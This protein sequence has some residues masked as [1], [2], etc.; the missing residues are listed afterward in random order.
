MKKS[1]YGP[2]YR[3]ATRYIHSFKIVGKASKDELEMIY[4]KVAKQISTVDRIHT[5][6][7]IFNALNTGK[8]VYTEILPSFSGTRAAYDGLNNI[9][10][11][12]EDADL[13]LSKT[14]EQLFDTG[15]F[16]TFVHEAIHKLQNTKLIYK[17]YP[18]RGMVEGATELMALRANYKNRSF[19]FN[20][21]SYNFNQSPYYH[22]VS[23]MAQLEVIFG[24]D[25]MQRFAFNGDPELMNQFKNMIG[26]DYFGFICQ[27]TYLES[28]GKE[29][30]FN[31]QYLQDFI[32]DTCFDKLFNQVNNLQDAEQ[33]LDKLKKMESVRARIKGDNK[34]QQYYETQL[35]KLLEKFPELNREKYKYRQCEFNPEWYEDEKEE[36]FRD[37][38]ISAIPTPKT[39]EEFL[40]FD[41]ESIKRYRL[42]KDEHLYEVIQYG[43]QKL[44]I[45]LIRPH[46]ASICHE[47]GSPM[48]YIDE[49]N[50]PYQTSFRIRSENGKTYLSVCDNGRGV[51]FSEAEMQE[52]PSGITPE[53]IYKIMK[54]DEIA[55]LKMETLWEKLSRIFRR[56]KRLPP[57][58]EITD[59]VKTPKRV[60]PIGWAAPSNNDKNSDQNDQNQFVTKRKIAYPSEPD[61]KDSSDDSDL[62]DNF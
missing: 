49:E 13:I 33:Y 41:V 46:R 10:I 54:E 34:F 50:K 23:I 60:T 14:N 21:E 42:E 5:E 22:L 37:M 38:A 1:F 4:R 9:F 35:N 27:D 44:L 2:I 55:D 45:Q 19:T 39:L 40:K 18:I 11:P 58:E 26:K 20:G 7:E 24:E 43:D 36:F 51:D 47:K 8:I 30:K 59:K 12:K 32:L 52:I 31:F 16:S 62:D 17:G 15:S 53:D 56:Q 61:F 57:F 28:R 48:K 29:T 3:L 25:L 6:E